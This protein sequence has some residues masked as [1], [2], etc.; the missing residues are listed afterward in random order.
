VER[1]PPVSE[2]GGAL[3]LLSIASTKRTLY[4]F[5]LMPVFADRATER[6]LASLAQ[7]LWPWL[8]LVHV[9]LFA[10]ALTAPFYLPL[11][12]LEIPDNVLRVISTLGWRHVFAAILLMLAVEQV[13]A[14]YTVQPCWPAQPALCLC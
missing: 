5:P 10:L 6:L 9:F 7:W 11:L 13:G 8:D 2:L 3:L 12:P 4:L 1:L 14:K